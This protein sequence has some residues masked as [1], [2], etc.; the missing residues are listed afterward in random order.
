MGPDAPGDGQSLPLRVLESVA[1]NVTQRPVDL[2]SDRDLVFELHCLGNYEGDPDWFRGAEFEAYRT[3]WL[4]T[5]QPAGFLQSLADSSND[6]RTIAEVWEEDGGALGFLWVRFYE[7]G[8]YGLTVAEVADIAVVPERQRLGTGSAMLTHAEELARQRGTHLLRADV[9]SG[10][11][12][13]RAL[14]T[15]RGFEPAR[16]TYEKVLG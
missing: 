13:S 3:K 8:G 6:S 5:S 12:A 10:N 1:M 11:T 14:H 16:L 7:I 4:S 2:E 9:G 15:A